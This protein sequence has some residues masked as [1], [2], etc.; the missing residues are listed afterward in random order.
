LL[1]LQSL[2]RACKVMLSNN[3]PEARKLQI[4]TQNLALQES[5]PEVECGLP[6]ALP[7]REFEASHACWLVAHE[8]PISDD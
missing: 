8:C 3:P 7:H 1:Y 5:L 4:A 6:I 2:A